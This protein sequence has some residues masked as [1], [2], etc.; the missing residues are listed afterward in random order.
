MEKVDHDNQIR[1]DQYKLFLKELQKS[2]IIK[3]D[4]T[5]MTLDYLIE[6]S[7]AF[8]IY[9][10]QKKYGKEIIS[11]EYIT[12]VNNL[13]YPYLSVKGSNLLNDW[14]SKNRIKSTLL[15]KIE[16]KKNGNSKKIAL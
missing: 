15:K 2:D 11:S 4:V 5:D 7:G 10:F 16:S 12:Y 3:Q 14:E 13:V 1:T 9:Y 8:R 6:L